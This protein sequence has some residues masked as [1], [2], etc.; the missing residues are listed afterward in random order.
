M[1]GVLE[2]HPV[3]AD[4]CNWLTLRGSRTDGDA[5]MFQGTTNLREPEV[6][7]VSHLERYLDC[8]FKYFASYVLRLDEERDEEAGLTPQE[9]GQ[10]VHAVFER[11]FAQWQASGG[12][13]ITTQNLPDAL[14]MFADV[15]EAQLASLPEA[16]RAMERTHLLGSAAA[17]GLAERA[18][19]FEID[20]GL[21]VRE[22]L[23]EHALEGEFRFQGTGG[24]K[25]KR[26]LQLAVYGICAEQHL[27][28]RHGRAWTLGRA[29]YVAFR[30]KNA[31]VEL[32]GSAAHLAKAL[33]DGQTRLLDAV[34]AIQAGSFPVRPDE[35]WLC[36]RCGFS[37]VCRKDYVGDE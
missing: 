33:A 24:P 37:L 12:G 11:F 30:E 10:F 36:T 14:A 28:G 22:R 17:P 8:P 21:D 9:R 26:S 6:Y 35:P 25:P 7:A 15:A 32:G 2:P 34:E 19:T 29:G 16:D 13:S 31:F 23:L 5:D 3:S 18:F 1:D 27:E 4:A 20:H